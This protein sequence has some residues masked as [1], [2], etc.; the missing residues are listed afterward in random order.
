MSG[1][2]TLPDPRDR[3]ALTERMGTELG[4]AANGDG[5]THPLRSLRFDGIQEMADG[6]FMASVTCTKPDCS[7][8]FLL[9]IREDEHARLLNGGSRHD[10]P[11]SSDE[12]R[13]VPHDGGG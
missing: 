1:L 6:G 13:M 7:G 10:G 2:G 4:A 12:V 9:P 8:S 3:L 11:G 5:C